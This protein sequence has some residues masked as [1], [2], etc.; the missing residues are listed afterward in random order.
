VEKAIKEKSC[1]AL[2]LKVL[3]TKNIILDEAS[4]YI[5]ASNSEQFYLLT[6][7]IR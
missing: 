5:G 7:F 6:Q 1:N 3:S 2:L 4:Y